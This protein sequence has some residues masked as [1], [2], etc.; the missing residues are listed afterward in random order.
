MQANMYLRYLF[1]LK[2][3]GIRQLNLGSV[4]GLMT[5]DTEWEELERH[6][7]FNLF[8]YY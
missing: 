7:K 5:G 8:G 2:C 1:Y 3:K 6:Q 4:K